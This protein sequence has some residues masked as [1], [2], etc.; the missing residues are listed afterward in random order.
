MTFRSFTAEGRL[1]AFV[2]LACALAFPRGARAEGEDRRAAARALAEEGIR[3]QQEGNCYIA[4]DRLERAQALFEAPPHLLHIA[5][6]QEAL[7]RLVAASDT[8][9][10]LVGTSIM[11]ADPP[12]FARARETGR[13]ALEKL[14]ARVPGVVIVV[15]P[16]GAPGLKVTIDGHTRPLEALGTEIALDPGSYRIEAS[17]SS[18]EPKAESVSLAAGEHKTVVLDLGSGA[19]ASSTSGS[20]RVKKPRGVLGLARTS[21]FTSFGVALGARVSG[22]FTGGTIGSANGAPRQAASESFQNGA[23]LELDVG[24]R[25][26]KRFHVFGFYSAHF[27][28]AGTS[29]DSKPGNTHDASVLHDSVGLGGE[30]ASD[31]II[32]RSVRLRAELGAVPFYR[33]RIEDTAGTAAGECSVRFNAAGFAGRAGFGADIALA[34]D[35]VLTP[36]GLA[37]FGS[38]GRSSVASSPS[39]PSSCTTPTSASGP[40][41]DRDLLWTLSAG[42]GISW[43]YP[44][45]GR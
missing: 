14:T 39:G 22:A 3:L 32:G 37:T 2:G 23:G 13:E 19:L 44:L 36:F 5:E 33:F 35:F 4:I 40:I 29:F 12:A 1:L 16:D 42:I 45:A 34:D 6:C 26:A 7:G 17:A 25:F 8:Y 41:T 31:P 11:P 28:A 30:I 9:K 15:H 10:K 21:N 38:L 43:G 20:D 18:F 27:L 24:M